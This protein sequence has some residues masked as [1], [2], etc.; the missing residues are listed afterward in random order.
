MWWLAFGALLVGVFWLGWYGVERARGSSAE[1]PTA[2]GIWVPVVLVGAGA[3]V[4]ALLLLTRPLAAIRTRRVTATAERRL[5][6]AVTSVAR[7]RV[8]APVRAVLRDYV[9]AHSALLGAGVGGRPQ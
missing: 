9:D 7:E 5:T 1:V 2:L 6:D 8:V 4:L 3:L